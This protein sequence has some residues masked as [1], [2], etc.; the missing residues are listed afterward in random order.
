M[1]KK[2]SVLLGRILIS[3][4]CFFLILLF[5]KTELC[6]FIEKKLYDY[7]FQIRDSKYSIH[8]SKNQSPLDDSGE[9][10]AIIVGIDKKTLNKYTDPIIFWD[11]EFAELIKIISNTGARAIVFDVLC[12]AN[13]SEKRCI[14]DKKVFVESVALSNK[15]ILPFLIRK[16]DIDI[17]VQ[18]L[19]YLKDTMGIST[20]LNSPSLKEFRIKEMN[21]SSQLLSCG[22]GFTNLSND[23]DGVVREIELLNNYG[24]VILPSLS[25]SAIMRYLNADIDDIRFS[26]N[27]LKIKKVFIP[28]VNGKMI[29]NYKSPPCTYKSISM[30]DVLEEKNKGKFLGDLF[31]DKIVLIGAYD[32]VLPDFHPTPYYSSFLGKMN[33]MFGVEIIANVL[34]TIL[35]QRFI[36]KESN[37]LFIFIL[38][39]ASFSGVILFSRMPFIKGMLYISFII[40]CYLLL[41]Y[42]TFC[43]LNYWLD[44]TSFVVALPFSFLTGYVYNY[45]WADKDK[46]FLK[47][48]FSSYLDRR[49]VEKLTEESNMNILKGQRR[50]ITVLFSDIRDFTSLSE[51]LKDSSMVV[52]I[53]NCFFPEMCEIILQNEGTVDKFMGDAIMAFWNAPNEVD[54]HW[55]KACLTAILMQ[56]KMKEIN[57]RIR[58][59]GIELKKDLRIGIGINTGKAVV[60]NIGSFKKSDYT[61]IGDTVNIASRLEGINKQYETNIIISEYTYERIKE[62]FVVRE[63]GSTQVKGREGSIK[64]YELISEKKS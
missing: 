12:L 47:E 34:D 51:S 11:K 56:D 62:N 49:V 24:D 3:L 58:S 21:A 36:R 39:L 31:D 28:L 52:E 7:R 48:T 2:L 30:V 19:T 14:V 60:G 18:I 26:K 22:F 41:G 6:S 45:F 15:S 55:F 5:S 64:I 23:K 46:R 33:N 29:I 27:W 42:Y 43:K 9:F 20:P 16:D 53:L 61:A 17:P 37:I 1:K 25:L 57:E 35:N 32:I 63:L 10:P 59:K 13:I 38:L 4:S 40:M 54:N 44:I 8:A 50:E